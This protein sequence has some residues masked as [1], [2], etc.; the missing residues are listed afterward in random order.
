MGMHPVNIADERSVL[1]DLLF[2]DNRD[3]LLGEMCDLGLIH[4]SLL[5]EWRIF[6]APLSPNS[7]EWANALDQIFLKT[8]V[9]LEKNSYLSPKS[10]RDIVSN[11]L[12]A[13][14]VFDVNVHSFDDLRGKIFLDVG[15]GIYRSF[16]VSMIMYCNGVDKAYAFEPY[17]LQVDFVYHSFLKM[18]E[19]MSNSPEN[20]IFSGVSVDEFISRLKT[21][22]VPGLHSK[23]KKINDN[24]TKELLK[25]EL[26]RLKNV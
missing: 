3:K 11:F 21:F 15:S 2:E 18:I 14:S 24:K 17:P 6:L 16:N 10:P 4:P 20:F 26:E 7:R 8:S 12:K 9:L 23:I 13:A 25:I 1:W 22:I 5:N 19:S